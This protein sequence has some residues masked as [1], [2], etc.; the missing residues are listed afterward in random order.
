MDG[1]KFNHCMR[2]TLSHEFGHFAGLRDVY[3]TQ[4]SEYQRYTMNG[5]TNQNHDKETLECEDK[6][7]LHHKYGYQYRWL[8]YRGRAAFGQ[9]H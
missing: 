9:P 1:G 8:A 5:A 4:C 3:V 2:N 7:A 6:F